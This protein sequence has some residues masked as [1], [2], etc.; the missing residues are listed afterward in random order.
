[1]LTFPLPAA[2]TL[3]DLTVSFSQ[4]AGTCTL[5]ITSEGAGHFVKLQT[6]GPGVCLDPSELRALCDWILAT[7]A[8][9]DAAEATP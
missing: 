4:N 2:S 8:T 9:C 1:M 7:C 5:T 3:G 6:D